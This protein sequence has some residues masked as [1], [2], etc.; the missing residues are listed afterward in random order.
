MLPSFDFGSLL[1]LST[2]LENDSLVES[3][4][5]DSMPLPHKH[6]R[7]S[8]SPNLPPSK[9]PRLDSLSANDTT[10]SNRHAK[11]R[12]KRAARR[13]TDP[14]PSHKTLEKIVHA[15]SPITTSLRAEDL[16][17]AKGAYSATNEDYEGAKKV[18]TVDELVKKEGFTYVPWDGR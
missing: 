17:S 16:P 1:K 13:I 10:A 9:R 18:W 7:G 8:D 11:R 4:D 14:F 6:P 3:N 12:A 15:S 5:E 2:A